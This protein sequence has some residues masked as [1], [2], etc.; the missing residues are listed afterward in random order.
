MALLVVPG[1][2]RGSSRDQE[3][4]RDSKAVLVAVKSVELLIC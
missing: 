4:E 2:R 1:K 3:R